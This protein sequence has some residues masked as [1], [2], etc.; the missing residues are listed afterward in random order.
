MLAGK[1]VLVVEDE[2]YIA[3]DMRR[4]LSAAGATVVGP[5]ASLSKAEAAVDEGDFDCAVIDLNLGAKARFRSR[6]GSQARAA[7]SRS[8]R[9]TA[10]KR[11]PSTLKE[12]RGS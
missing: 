1:R 7:A 5:C 11:S 10:R 4:M 3:D 2:Y 6:S 9:A 12:C 8:R